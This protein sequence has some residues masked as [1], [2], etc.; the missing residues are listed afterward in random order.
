L[1][2]E[3]RL[4]EYQNH[5]DGDY[6]AAV[7]AHRFVEFMEREHPDELAEWLRVK[8]VAFV[9]ETIK[10]N[11][12]RERQRV[13]ARAGARAFALAVENGDDVAGI[14]KMRFV[15]DDLNTR[16]PLGDMTADDCRFASDNYAAQS[17]RAKAMSSFLRVLAD[18][19]G[20]STVADVFGERT[21]E[22]LLRSFVSP[23]IT[24]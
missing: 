13:V 16:R 15:V 23:L 9:T 22:D 21:C 7:E 19:V 20:E 11:E 1:S 6:I 10:H 4:V 12:N 17:V 14:F 18:R 5:L 3:L 8:A 24:V 2:L